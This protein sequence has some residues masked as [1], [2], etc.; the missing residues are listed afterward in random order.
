MARYKCLAEYPGTQLPDLRLVPTGR[1][2]EVPDDTPARE[3]W[4]PLDDAAHAA[5]ERAK[6]LAAKQIKEQDEEM[7]RMA[8]APRRAFKTLVDRSPASVEPEERPD[9]K[10]VGRDDAVL[11]PSSA[12]KTL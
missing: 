11:T 2:F 6:L 7:A 5:V 12:R 10:R 1:V 9:T 8:K 4:L 3:S